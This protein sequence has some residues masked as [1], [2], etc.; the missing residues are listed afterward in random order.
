[1]YS[2][3]VWHLLQVLFLFLMVFPGFLCTSSFFLVNTE[4][5]AFGVEATLLIWILNFD[6]T[7]AIFA[8]V[9]WLYSVPPGNCCDKTYISHSR[10]FP[11]LFNSFSHQSLQATAV[12]K[13]I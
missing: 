4:T 2:S 1:V 7:P 9:L 11:D 3:T 8:E 5:K 10:F 13:P 6:G 12:M